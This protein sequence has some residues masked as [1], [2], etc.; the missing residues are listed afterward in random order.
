MLVSII[1]PVYNQAQYLRQAIESALAQD[2]STLPD[3]SIEVIV[4]NDASTDDSL[5]IAQ[6]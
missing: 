3:V 2:I 5:K 6:K 1:I 4:V